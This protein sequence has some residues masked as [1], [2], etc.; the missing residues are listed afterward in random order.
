MRITASHL[1]R[2]V[3][4][5]LLNSA[6]INAL[7]Y[8]ST[9]KSMSEAM[10]RE[11]PNLR[12]V[13]GRSNQQRGPVR[14][15]PSAF[16]MRGA[17]NVRIS[18]PPLPGTQTLL[19]NT[20]HRLC[21]FCT[22]IADSPCQS[23]RIAACGRTYELGVQQLPTTGTLFPAYVR[24]LAYLSAGNGKASASEFQKL[25]D[26]RSDMGNCPLGALTFLG[27]ARAYAMEAG[28]RL[29]GSSNPAATRTGADM[30]SLARAHRAY[31]DFLIFGRTQTPTSRS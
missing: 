1:N 14:R 3:S 15:A 11:V 9:G 19:T 20:S 29:K 5:Q 22:S 7:H 23:L 13:N 26:H 16:R 30:G 10:P 28:M 6:E 25:L 2:L 17:W 27:L 8:Q 21:H 4:H 12:P 24:G 31:G 18:Y